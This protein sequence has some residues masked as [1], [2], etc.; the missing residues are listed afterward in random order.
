MLQ[1]V[2]SHGL[3]KRTA[4][5][6]GDNITLTDIDEAWGAVHSHVGMS[7]FE[8]SVLAHVLQIVSADDNSS[9]HLVRDHHALQDTAADRNVTGKGA[10][11]IDIGALNRLSGGLESQANV[12]EETHTLLTL[13]AKNS[14]SSDED[15]VLLLVCLLGL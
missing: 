4:L 15:S 3:G 6:D 5:A 12:L 7:L 8:S 14:L 11:L 1:N 2:E 13:L 10:L 9:L